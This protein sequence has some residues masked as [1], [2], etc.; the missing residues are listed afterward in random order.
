MYINH[1]PTTHV[2]PPRNVS[3]PTASPIA[4][5]LQQSVIFSYEGY[6]QA[7]VWIGSCIW[8]VETFPRAAP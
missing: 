5:A 8:Q 4:T 1:T 3:V 7:L 2:D 6:Y